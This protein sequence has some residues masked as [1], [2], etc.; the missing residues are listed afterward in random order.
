MDIAAIAGMLA[1]LP[2]DALDQLVEAI[3]APTDAPGPREPREINIVPDGYAGPVV[4]EHDCA[5]GVATT[6]PCTE[7]EQ[8]VRAIDDEAQIDAEKAQIEVAKVHAERLD[9][10]RAEAEKSPAFSAL[11][12]ELGVL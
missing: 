7:A 2:S 12:T 6:R 9:L 10:I 3:S 1:G 8:A 11:A 5:T 4:V